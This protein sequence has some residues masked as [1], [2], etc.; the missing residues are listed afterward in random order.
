MTPG[1]S[2]PPGDAI[3]RIMAVMTAAFDPAYGEAWTRRQVEDALLMGHSRAVL[4]GA[5]GLVAPDGA[6]P[7]D[8]APAALTA[9]FA[10]LRTMF[11][12]EELLLFAIS[13]PWRRRGL[14]ALLLQ[15]VIATARAGGIARMLLEMRDGNSAEH[16]YRAFGFVPVGRRAKYYRTPSGLLLD[17]ITFSSSLR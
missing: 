17:A 15:Q 1:G 9:G 8:G 10:L 16:L 7:P 5:D 14:G 3:D 2:T 12:E 13:P 4:I 11:D 6:P